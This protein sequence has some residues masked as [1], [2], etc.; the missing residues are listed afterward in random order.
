[1]APKVPKDDEHAQIE[2][3]WEAEDLNLDEEP[4]YGRGANKANFLFRDGAA[5]DA[6]AVSVDII[7]KVANKNG[8][9]TSRPSEILFGVVSGRKHLVGIPVVPDTPGATKIAYK[10]GRASGTLFPIFKRLD[11]LVPEGYKE[12]YFVKQTPAKVKVRGVIGWG[13]YMDLE[14]FET[15][16]IKTLSEEELAKRQA[17]AAANKA[18]KLAA[19]KAAEEAARKAAEE[20]SPSAQDSEAEQETEE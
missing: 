19:K 12:R 15:E 9:G 1:M 3:I 10:D 20:S 7:G 5:F 8:L 2:P 16:P 13:I 6:S 11:R 18:A 4:V 14:D 17:T